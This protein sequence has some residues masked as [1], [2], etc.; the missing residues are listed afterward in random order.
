MANSGR[1]RGGALAPAQ[2]GDSGG[3]GSQGWV[4][5]GGVPRQ[6]S[7]S[8]N[9]VD[10]PPIRVRRPK[11]IYNESQLQVINWT[12][13]PVV[14]SAG[15]GAGKTESIIARIVN[16]IS[17]GVDARSI[18]AT[19]FTKKAAEEMNSRLKTRGV[20]TDDMS[21]Q[22]MHSFCF[23]L[24]KKNGFDSWEVDD[25]DQLNIIIKSV[26]GF[27]G[28]K[29]RGCDITLV[30]QFISLA[31]NSLIRPEAARDW[32]VFRN[33][34]FFGDNRYIEAYLNTEETRR[35]KK[36]LTF[37]DMLIDGV[38]LLQKNTSVRE[39]NQEKYNFVIVDEFQDSNQAQITLMDLVAAP[40]WNLM[41]VG[42][43]DQ[44]IFEF[45]GAVPEFM[46]NF[47]EKY[48]AS[49]ISMGVNYRCTPNI[50]KSAASCIVNNQLRI[51]KDLT[52]N[53]AE[54]G[55]II[56]RNASDQDE[57]A[58]IVADEIERLVSEDWK[59]GNFFV[60][61]RCNAQSRALEEVFSK[62]KLPHVVL[63]GGSFYQ[64]KEIQDLLS[65]LRLIVNP[66]D[67]ESGKRAISR[68]FR[69]V[70]MNVLENI[71]ET[72]AK[73]KCGYVEA[74]R[75]CNSR[76]NNRGV[77]DFY[78]LMK[79]FLTKIEQDLKG[80]HKNTVGELISWI[81]SKTN[82]I[83]YL[84]QNEGSDTLENSRAAN[85][86]ELI[87]SADRYY[88]IEEFLRFVNWQIQQR[89]KQQ[90]GDVSDVIQCMSCH[91]SKGM[92]RR[93]VFLIGVNEGIL[94]HANAKEPYEE[95]RRLF[96]VGMTRAE[97]YLHI[98]YVE[99]LGMKGKILDK[100]R[101][102]DEAGLVL[103]SGLTSLAPPSDNS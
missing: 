32:N 95:E 67:S 64:R 27:K 100:S 75:I 92:E 66:R 97:N 76:Y 1:R 29:W 85:V 54:P 10:D 102:I 7:D 9:P 38:E 56:C 52:S 63:G 80:G 37:D 26:T 19:T 8:A 88:D 51:S 44:S 36:L 60:L 11:R 58:N 31:K 86:G 4:Q 13:G 28:M 103:S 65:Y 82:F 71:E 81:V 21:V 43:V 96:Y 79:E 91:K 35:N 89:K 49:V 23:R 3:S 2:R 69:Y 101:F 87:R 98:S 72:E 45:R 16:L 55:T 68:P 83:D 84:T 70:A 15:P 46:V 53:K 99:Q 42:D 24:L 94:P 74:C 34:P 73:Q 57:E 78:Y 20:D 22:T 93:G 5:S 47:Q 41:V 59:F 30:E 48:S 14:V 18:L 77:G 25:I 12:T 33:G 90:K 6:L 61:Y 17:C 39:R 40:Q 62:R 50:V